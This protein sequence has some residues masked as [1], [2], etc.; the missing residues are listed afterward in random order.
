VTALFDV[1]VPAV[2]TAELVGQFQPGSPEWH[3]ARE[4]ALGGSE[5]AAMLGLSKW[6]SPYSLWH[7][8]A[9][10]IGP[11]E[12]TDAMRWGNRFEDDIAEEFQEQHPDLYVAAAGTY[13]N[14]QRPWQIANPDRLF[15]DREGIWRGLE[16]KTALRADDWGTSGSDEIPIYYRTQVMHY[17][18]TLGIEEFI[19]AVL[20]LS[21]W[22][23]R[24][25]RITYDARDAQV[26]RDAGIAFM[27]SLV[28]GVPPDLD[29]HEETY[30]TVMAL[31][32]GRSG[33]KVEIPASLAVAYNGA[34]AK[35]TEAV[36]EKR[37]ASSRVL[38]AIGTGKQA[39]CNG[40][41]IATRAVK[42]D[43]TTHALQPAK[44]I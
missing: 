42:A 17:M 36:S 24:E 25:Y 32:E 6:E 41:A 26:M 35:Y 4:N 34:C 37:F 43:G 21:S 3:A 11:V 12:Q 23:Y 27:D 15:A 44:G 5:A 28:T 7:R 16:I 14:T 39:T 33:E 13:R 38:A 30:K 31:A 18:D 20:F 40:L 2:L 1:P 8:K 10:L 19:L 29:D 9:G 22:S